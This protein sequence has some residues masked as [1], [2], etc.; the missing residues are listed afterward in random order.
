MKRSQE[1]QIEINKLRQRIMDLPEDGTAEQVAEIR[2]RNVAG[3][4]RS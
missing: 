2:S 1:L 3:E 4:T